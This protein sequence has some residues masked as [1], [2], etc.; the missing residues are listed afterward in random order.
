V[1]EAQDCLGIEKEL[2]YKIFGWERSIVSYGNKQLVRKD[3]L[4]WGIG[5]QSK[6]KNV[7]NLKVSYR[8]KNNLV[9][10]F[11]SYSELI[12]KG[13]SWELRENKNIPGGKIKI[14]VG[15]GKYT[16]LE[17]QQNAQSLVEEKDSMYDMMFFTPS[18][19]DGHE[20]SKELEETLIQWGYK[21]FNSTNKKNNE[22]FPIDEHRIIN[23]HSCRGLEAW[24][25]VLWRLDVILK[26]I[27]SYYKHDHDTTCSFEEGLRVYTDNW[28]F[29]LFTRAIDTLIIT[30]E[31]DS[32]EEAQAILKLAE[33]SKFGH[34]AQIVRPI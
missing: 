11:N 2:I 7:V 25:T 34:M 3:E 10:F 12:S 26:E 6:N 20:Y 18:K 17:H 33:N 27:K 31:D 22:H 9:D 29:M 32:T 14:F 13:P 4:D 24:I 30:L 28:I 15:T 1:D 21:A 5:I 23:F 16:K 19:R 8:N